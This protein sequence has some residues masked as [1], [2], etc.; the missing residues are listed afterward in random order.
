M[1]TGIMKSFFHLRGL[2]LF[3]VLTVSVLVLAGCQTNGPAKDVNMIPI[4]HDAAKKMIFQSKD[5]L[6]PGSLI[7]ASFADIDN[8]E[9][10]STF[11]RIVAQQIGS[12]FSS[13]GY[14]IIEMLLRGKVYIGKGEGEFLLSR[15][16]KDLSTEHNAQAVIVG[17]YAVGSKNVYVTAKLIQASDSII[18][19]SEDFVL[20]LGPDLRTLVTQPGEAPPT[21]IS[22]GN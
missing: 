10:S 14:K 18:L 8:L 7:L 11:G 21:Y 16:L 3:L 9:N 22:S 4:S 13:Q 1:R 17:I 20:P 15:A 12:V 2:P 19:A 6:E 5:R